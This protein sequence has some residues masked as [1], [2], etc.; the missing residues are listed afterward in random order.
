VL[1]E[2]QG[3]PDT[4]ASDLVVD[5]AGRGSRAPRWLTEMGYQQPDETTIGVDF[6]YSSTK[7]L[8]PDWY[9]ER[10]RLLIFFGPA[11]LCPN[12]AIMG[13]IQ[14]RTW[15]VSLAGRFGDY[16]PDDEDGFF[17][18]AKSL[19]T[20]KLY[21]LIKDAKRV[22]EIKHYRYP[23]SLLRHYERLTSF[24]EGFVVL[25]DAI[26]SFNPVYGQGMSSAAQQVDALRGLLAVRAAESQGLAGL[27]QAFFSKAAEVVATPWALAAGQDL[28]YPQTTGVRPPNMEENGQY[29]AMLNRLAQE[30]TEVFRLMTEVFQL[31][32]PLSALMDEPLRSRVLAQRAM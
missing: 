22:D 11:P 18:F 6:A 7:F 25:G 19:Y 29:F 26:S 5:A 10:E 4:L 17:A 2:T 21:S 23:T 31:A 12:G 13:E 8:I 3:G 15:H 32:R 16:P 20:P 30:D 1:Y 14:D 24:P 28:A 9:D 27:A